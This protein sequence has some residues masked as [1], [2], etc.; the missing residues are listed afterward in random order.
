M[1]AG[2]TLHV[3]PKIFQVAS[4]NIISSVSLFTPNKE[5][6]DNKEA[7]KPAFSFGGSGNGTGQSA[8][9]FG[10]SSQATG[11]S[12]FGSQ[13]TANANAP[14]PG[15]TNFSFGKNTGNA[16]TGLSFGNSSSGKSNAFSFGNPTD[17]NK[18]G[19]AFNLKGNDQNQPSSTNGLNANGGA[20]SLSSSTLNQS[21]SKTSLFG[22]GQQS[23][24]TVFGKQNEFK[25]TGS[26]FGSN[27]SGDGAKPAS[28]SL[29]AGFDLSAPKLADT[30]ATGGAPSLFGSQ[31]S[32]VENKALSSNGP[33]K[34]TGFGASGNDNKATSTFSFGNQPAKPTG[35]SFGAKDSNKTTAP[36][37]GDQKKDEK[38][39]PGLSTGG[40]APTLSSFESNVATDGKDGGNTTGT[41]KSGLFSFGSSDSK[42]QGNVGAFSLSVGNDKGDNSKQPAFS[43]GA[44]AGKSAETSEASTSSAKPLFSLN[45]KGGTAASSAAVGGT[46]NKD[47]ATKPA[48]SFGKKDQDKN[49]SLP[50]FGA[51][52]DTKTDEQAK[53]ASPAFSF[54]AKPSNAN[55]SQPGFSFGAKSENDKD[56]P[57]SGLSFGAKTG[58]DQDQATAA[59]SFNKSDDK[60]KSD[61][62]TP[63]F[64][65]GAKPASEKSPAVG[66]NTNDTKQFSFGGAKD[67][68]KDKATVTGGFTLGDKKEDTK[69]EDTKTTSGASQILNPKSV[70]PAPVSLD[71]KTLDDLITK[72]TEQ[73]SGT[74]SHFDAFSKKVNQWDQILVKGGEEINQLYSETIAT[75]QTQNRID[76]SLQ[77]IERHQDELEAFLDSYEQ[78]TE[79]LLSDVLSSTGGTAAI[80]N[81]HKRQQAYRTAENLDENL[82]SLSLNLSSLIAEI[83]EVSNTFNK[84]T[85]MNLSNNDEN[86]QLVKLLNSHLE[87][88]KSLDDSSSALE[89][90]IKLISK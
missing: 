26:L 84:A 72:W 2:A 33:G 80:D 66:S 75:E 90:K 63:G 52:A 1:G 47:M 21:N 29:G 71:N 76:Q 28:S 15:S 10:G 39:T 83:N 22:S 55:K 16:T 8:F 73:L 74:A 82:N 79:A 86:T 25:P 41:P 43:F 62:T 51:K 13:P 7:A 17:S 44:K 6:G 59:F 53:P 48:F 11:G 36:V 89:S 42:K 14:K 12:V 37:A 38:A 20:P 34:F 40:S 85:T 67:G 68:E 78:R 49:A 77:Y 56:K 58:N 64:S 30:K 18:P 23:S 70:E 61:K 9:T 35:F 45:D 81:D 88:L 27:T 65:F 4:T 57:A 5:A 24:S 60:S 3:F 19:F 87:A 31:D 69:K 32:K 46:E 50:T 54:G